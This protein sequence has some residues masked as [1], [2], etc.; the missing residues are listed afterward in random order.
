MHA[1]N[2]S[3]TP[4]LKLIRNQSDVLAEPVDYFKGK[5][6]CSKNVQKVSTFFF[7]LILNKK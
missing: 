6:P 4:L 1:E 2:V 5:K 3:E 7:K